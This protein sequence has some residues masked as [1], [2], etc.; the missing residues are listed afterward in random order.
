MRCINV[1]PQIQQNST[2]P[3]DMDWLSI[4]GEG[5]EKPT[6]NRLGLTAQNGN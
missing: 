1:D 6:I 5:S 4:D 2:Y 3:N